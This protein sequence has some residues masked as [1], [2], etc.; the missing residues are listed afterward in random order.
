MTTEAQ[1]WPLTGNGSANTF[2]LQ[3]IH[4]GKMKGFGSGVF[5]AV[6]TEHEQ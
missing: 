5:Y 1:I 3:R 2:L 6:R 4:A